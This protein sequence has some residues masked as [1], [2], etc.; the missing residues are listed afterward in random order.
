M[1]RRLA[2]VLSVVGALGLATPAAAAPRASGADLFVVQ[3]DPAPV[4]AG[5]TTTVHAFVANK[6]PGPAGEFTVTVRVPPGATAVGPYFPANCTVH[7]GGHRVRCTFGAGLPALRSA[8]ALVP[9][10]VSDWASG[11]LHGGRVTVE[12]AGDP[13]PSND[14]APYEIRVSG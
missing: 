12:T 14:S 11:T 8:T 2:L 1:K 4:A 5:G 13:D 9:V 10:K 7:D 6:G 3:M